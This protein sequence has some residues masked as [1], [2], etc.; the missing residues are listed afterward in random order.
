[1]ALSLCF[2]VRKYLYC[3]PFELAHIIS[4][5]FP[6]DDLYPSDYRIEDFE[7]VRTLDQTLEEVQSTTKNHHRIQFKSEYEFQLVI[8][9]TPSLGHI[10][11]N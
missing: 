1:M 7:E 9:I 5:S 2:R 4:N 6:G 10:Y 11:L 8:N 3:K